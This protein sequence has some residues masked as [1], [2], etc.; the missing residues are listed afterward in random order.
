VLAAVSLL[1]PLA[2]QAESLH[3][4]LDSAFNLDVGGY[5]PSIDSTLRVD[6]AGG[7]G[8]EVDLEDDLDLNDRE[9]M[10]FALMNFRFGDRW[11]IEAEYFT[12]TREVTHVTARD[13]TIGDVIFP[14]GT[15][16]TTNFDSDIYRLSAGY[17]F[18]KRPNYEAGASLG[19]HVTTF[20]LGVRS[21]GGA[22]SES[23]D[24]LAPLVTLGLYGQYALS[25]KWLL[26]G[27]LDVFAL[28]YEEYSGSLVNFN[29]AVE[30]QVA[31]HFGLGLGYR[32]VDLNLEADPTLTVGDTEWGGEFDY[33]F[34]GPTLYLS[35]VF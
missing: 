30:Y 22:L 32:H 21:V 9:T 20:D 34:S 13:L 18:L 16:V 6:R 26:T 35:M 3:P 4:K 11:R 28:E 17:S 15:D 33:A 27:R 29:A 1:V 31:K 10:P 23:A 19:I 12:L 7:I 2:V 8:T 24:T 5:W 25:P 14:A